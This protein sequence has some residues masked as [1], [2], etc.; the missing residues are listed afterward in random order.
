MFVD[1]FERV[2]RNNYSRHSKSIPVTENNIRWRY[3]IVFRS[4]MVH[5]SNLKTVRNSELNVWFFGSVVFLFIRSIF[6]PQVHVIISSLMISNSKRVE[7][8]FVAES[9]FSFLSLGLANVCDWGGI[10]WVQGVVADGLKVSTDKEFFCGVVSLS[11]V[12][13]DFV[14]SFCE[15]IVTLFLHQAFRTATWWIEKY[16][17]CP[18]WDSQECSKPFQLPDFEMLSRRLFLSLFRIHFSKIWYS[19]FY[20]IFWN[21]RFRKSFLRF[22]VFRVGYILNFF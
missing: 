14:K 8:P 18:R 3:L 17:Q 20:T 9:L 22:G 16:L 12:E 15:S 4:N 19:D 11:C 2:E 10:F 21:L 13:F 5:F 1:K 6:S 7:Q